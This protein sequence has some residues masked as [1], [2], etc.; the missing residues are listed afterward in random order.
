MTDGY[1]SDPNVINFNDAKR[2]K[3]EEEEINSLFTAEDLYY[4]NLY[5]DA[6][7][8]EEELVINT[9]LHYMRPIERTMKRIENM[10]HILLLM[11]FLQNIILLAIWL[12]SI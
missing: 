7:T 3:V 4:R 1:A 10:Q 5:Y 9:V 11:F 12:T 2:K 8:E 6:I